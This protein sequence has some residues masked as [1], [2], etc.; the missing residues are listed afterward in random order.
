VSVPPW[1]LAGLWPMCSPSI[2]TGGAPLHA[3][4]SHSPSRDPQPGA[5]IEGLQMDDT[6]H[7]PHTPVMVGEIVD[8]LATVPAGVVVDGTV[9]D[10]GHARVV[11]ASVPRLSVIGLDRDPSAVGAATARLA[12]F[13]RRATVRHA[14]FSSMGTEVA[15]VQEHELVDPCRPVVGVLLD[16]G[17][18]SRQLDTPARGFSLRAEGPLDMRMDP[19]TGRSAEEVV[20]QAPEEELRRLFVTHGEGRLAGRLARAIVRARPLHTTAE[21]ADVVEAAVP[22]AARRRGHP[23]TRVFQALRVAVNAEEDELDQAL[24]TGI[25]LLAP[26]GRFLVLSYHSGEDRRVKWAFA[27]AARGG[28]TCPPDLPCGCGARPLHRLVFSGS[29]VPDADEVSG[30]R[31]ASSARLRVLERMSEVGSGDR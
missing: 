25:R 18:S 28:C 3:G 2:R 17:V 12:R 10:G 9:G 7:T 24:E 16:L 22:G 4:S 21:L 8:L 19:T 6:P 1:S 13:G 20:N 31:R 11:L 23:A 29:R 27:S 26:G 5:P 30:N 15:R 14:R